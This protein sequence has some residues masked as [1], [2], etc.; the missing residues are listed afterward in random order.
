MRRRST[1]AL[2]AAIPAALAVTLLTAPAAVAA[3]TDIV[4]N[5]VQSTSA[6]DA[7]DF[8]ELTNVG[9]APVDI[10][11]WIARD[12]KDEPDADFVTFP[13]GTVIEPGAIVAF[14]PDTLVGMGLGKEDAVRIFTATGTLV[15]EHRWSAHVSSEGRV[16]DGTG[17][18]VATEPT[19]GEANVTRA[20]ASPVVINEV[21]SNG[22]ARGDW[23][24]LANTDTVST[25]DLSGWSIVDGDP[26]HEPIVLPEG[27]TIESGGYRAIIT[28]GTAYNTDFGLGG[29]DTVTLRDAQGTVVDEFGWEAHAAVTWARC[30]DMTGDFVDAASATFEMANDC[31][32]VEEPVVEAD[33]WP[34]RDDVRPAVA[35]GTWGDDMSG[36]DHAADGTLFAVNNDN[37]EIFELAAGADG[38]WSIARSWVP[39]YPDG[40]GQ[41]DAEGLSVAGDGAI[42]LA[43]ERDNAAKS[44]SRPSILRVEL[45]ADGRATTTHEWNVSSALGE[46]GANLGP[47]AIEWISDADALRLGVVDETGARY[48][49]ASYGEHFGGIVAFAVEQ[50]GLIHLAVLEATGELTILQS[51]APSDALA[52]VMGLDWQAGGNALWAL[53]DEAC[54]NRHAELAFVDGRLTA[55][56]AV[57]APSTMDAGY[58]NEGLA[59][60]WCETD[61]TAAPAVAWISDTAHDGVSLRVSAGDECADVIETPAPTEPAPTEPAPTETAPGT[62]IEPGDGQGGADAG[63]EPTLPSTSTEA[64][65]V[66]VGAILLLLAAASLALARRRGATAE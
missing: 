2:A 28:D 4:I 32:P 33:A 1:A 34:F 48:D 18:F 31:G 26:E 14:E 56:R 23:V 30:A 25:V 52:V 43:T 5:E 11:G 61:A 49:P 50:T 17:A 46:L 47:E 19:P 60:D 53:C 7:P 6:T 13:A 24:E 27:T 57:H 15:A 65:V 42:L 40:S 54:D 36:L 39:T 58:T 45:G 29:S 12:D 10:S 44:T 59:I 55:Q 41:P 20:A 22:D 16:P 21:E 51:A 63:G 37:A 38:Q 35:P 9:A 8:F 66:L 62:P 64:P 3:D